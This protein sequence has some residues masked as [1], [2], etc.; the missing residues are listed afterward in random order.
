MT[1][2]INGS[3]YINRLRCIVRVERKVAQAAI[4]IAVDIKTGNFVLLYQHQK[5]TVMGAAAQSR[6]T[7]EGVIER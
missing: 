1:T 4:C 2:P 5:G 3:C 7:G 6:G